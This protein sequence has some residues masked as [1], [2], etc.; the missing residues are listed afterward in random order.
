M[1]VLHVSEAMGGGIA[2]SLLAMVDAT[3]ELDHHLLA[4]RRAE[5]D[6]GDDLAGRFSSVHQMPRNPARAVLA[7]RRVARRLYPDV[8]HAHSSYGGVV[9]RTAGLDRVRIVYSPHCFAFERRDITG[10]QRRA[11]EGIERL[12]ARR[13][14]LLVAVAPSEIDLA[15]GLGHREI[16]YTPNRSLLV[17]DERAR[18]A[19]PLRV[20]AVGRVSAQK[21][22]RYLLHVKRYAEAELGVR[23]T[24]EW[25]GGG[26]PAGE[27][28]LAAGGIHVSGWMP[29]E[30][31]VS[32]MAGAQVYLHTAAWEAA[33]ISIL[34]AAS[35]GLPLALRA[36]SPLQSLDL[37]GL[38]PSVKGLAER[39]ASLASPAAWTAA[40]ETSLGLAER[41]GAAVQGQHLRHAYARL[42]AGV[43]N[44]LAQPDRRALELEPRFS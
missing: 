41:H 11:Y 18:H 10:L 4:H 39:L 23:A 19:E 42:D 1:R 38:A 34:E 28:A 13:T 33:P 32:R 25:L 12:L 20:V 7:L 44:G 5:H 27:R 9:A 17:A 30:Q 8:V 29:R 22:W 43:R 36:I 35:V 26:D 3:P 14:D 16:A 24:W 15:V 40:Q 6:T 37:P 31:L 21:D 2:S